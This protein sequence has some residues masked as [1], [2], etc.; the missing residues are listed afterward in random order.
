M[1]MIKK[2]YINIFKAMFFLLFT[3]V[4]LSSLVKDAYAVQGGVLGV[5]EYRD[6]DSGALIKMS[7]P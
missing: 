2:I 6:K 4:F 5:L 1:K 3:V 7:N